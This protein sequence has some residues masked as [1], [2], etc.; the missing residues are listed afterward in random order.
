MLLEVT[1]HQLETLTDVVGH[2][3][4]ELREE[5]YK[6]ETTGFRKSLKE[7]EVELVGLLSRFE[8]AA[9]SGLSVGEPAA[10]A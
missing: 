7:R 8:A 3:L 10:K 6:T 9:D 1:P 2:A 5:I 4:G